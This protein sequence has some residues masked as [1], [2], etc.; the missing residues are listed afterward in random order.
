MIGIIVHDEK[1]RMRLIENGLVLPSRARQE[2][3]QKM[4]DKV[5]AF[6][7]VANL[8]TNKALHAISLIGN[9]SRRTSYEFTKE[10]IDK[11]EKAIQ[12]ETVKMR[13][14]FDLAPSKPTLTEFSL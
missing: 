4:T 1:T 5:A 14:K 6:K 9:L 11:I 12:E 3:I 8:R 10:D 13:A 7:R 2:E